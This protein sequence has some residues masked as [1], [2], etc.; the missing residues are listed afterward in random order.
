M[1]RLDFFFRVKETRTVSGTE[2]SLI[3]AAC[4]VE[5]NKEQKYMRTHRGRLK[6]VVDH[7]KKFVVNLIKESTTKTGESLIPS[8]NIS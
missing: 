6:F 1:S 5:A 8:K 7:N 3:G 2:L 4:V